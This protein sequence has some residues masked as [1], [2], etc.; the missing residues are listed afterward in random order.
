MASCSEASKHFSS[1]TFVVS[2]WLCLHMVWW[3][4]TPS[5]QQFKIYLFLHWWTWG[6]LSASSK[7]LTRVYPYLYL[8]IPTFVYMNGLHMLRECFCAHLD[9]IGFK[10]A[11]DLTLLKTL[12]KCSLAGKGLTELK[13]V[14][15][16]MS[17]NPSFLTWIC[18]K[19]PWGCLFVKTTSLSPG[20]P[21]SISAHCLSLLLDLDHKHFGA[22]TLFQNH[23]ILW[24]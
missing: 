1:S 24:S 7:H 2:F 19:I 23:S 8:T 17:K 15:L 16:R 22:E 21:P 20:P 9:R 6:F 3:R 14:F 11:T 13:T 4:I 12:G 18:P 10:C 5:T